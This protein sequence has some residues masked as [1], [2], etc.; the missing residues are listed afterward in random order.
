MEKL[1]VPPEV[2]KYDD[3]D[4]GLASSTWVEGKLKASPDVWHEVWYDQTTEED[5]DVLIYD[6]VE[7]RVVNL[8]PFKLLDDELLQDI[9]ARL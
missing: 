3:K 7:G 2:T 6:S 1:T 9:G 4:G 8:P 5:Y